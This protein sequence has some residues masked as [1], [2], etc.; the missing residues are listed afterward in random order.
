MNS[1]RLWKRH[2]VPLR[3]AGGAKRAK[4]NETPSGVFKV[5]VTTSSGT[6]LAGI[7]TRVMTFREA[8]QSGSDRAESLA[9]D[10]SALP[11]RRPCRFVGLA[12]SSALP[13]RRPY[14]FVGLISD[15]DF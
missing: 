15:I 13:T 9:A 10:S 8:L 14:R 6:G 4:R 2:A 3:P 1:A 12:D 5:P 7:E 11:I